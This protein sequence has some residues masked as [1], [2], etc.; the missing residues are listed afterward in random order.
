MYLPSESIYYELV[1]GKTG[2]LYAYSLG[3]RVFPVSPSTFHAYLAIIVL[4]LRGL[5]IERHAQEVMA[6]CAQLAKD[7]SRFRQD[8]DVVGKHIGNAASKY[9]E[10][11]RRL[12][13][14]E[15]RL[16]QATEPTAH[17]ETVATQELPLA[18]DPAYEPKAR[19]RGVGVRQ[20][21]PPFLTAWLC[22]ALI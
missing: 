16:E 6:Y 15:T 2:G 9:S 17:D 5:Q 3:K 14:L 22:S 8:F 18:L 11:D 4:G 20:S 7:F 12:E 19:V 13:R 1:C 21:T 10:A